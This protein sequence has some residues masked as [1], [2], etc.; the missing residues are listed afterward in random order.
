MR[1]YFKGFSGNLHTSENFINLW[2]SMRSTRSPCFALPIGM[3]TVP[4]LPFRLSERQTIPNRFLISRT[5]IVEHDGGDA[6]RIAYHGSQRQELNV[7]DYGYRR[8]SVRSDVMHHYEIVAECRD[9][10]REF[11]YHPDIP[12]EQVFPIAEPPWGAWS[13][14]EGVSCSGRIRCRLPQGPAS[15]FRLLRPHR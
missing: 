14:G 8:H 1:L 5:V 15:S 3:P 7:C 9:T 10:S 6:V 2:F 4:A 11:R 13:D 12:L